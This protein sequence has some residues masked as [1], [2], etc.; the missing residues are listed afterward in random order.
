MS[1][2]QAL[3][4]QDSFMGK[5]LKLFNYEYPENPAAKGVAIVLN[6]EITNVEGV[7]VHYL[8][9]GK[10][11][12]AVIPWHGKRTITVLGIYAPTESDEEKI[13]FWNEMC[14]LWLTTDLPVP[15]AIGGDLNL[16]PDAID[17]LPHHTDSDAVIAA[18]LRFTRLMEVKD[19]YRQN[20]PDTKAYTHV[21]TRGT[22]S[23]IDRILVSPTLMKHCRHWEIEDVAGGLMDHRMVS[24]T[25]S[26]PGAPYIGKGRWVMPQFLL[27]DKEFISHAMEEAVKLEES[28]H[29]ARTDVSNAQTRFKSFKD[30]VLEFAQKKAKATVGASEK[31]RRALVGERETLLNNRA[32]D[33]PAVE[34]TLD[35]DTTDATGDQPT[36]E[37]SGH[38]ADGKSQEEIAELVAVIEKKIDDI[39]DRQR[40][41][42]RL[43]TRVRGYTELNHITKTDIMPEKGSKRSSEMAEIARDYH[44]D[45]QS[46][47]TDSRDRADI[48]PLSE[49]LTEGDVSTALAEA[50]F[51]KAAGINGIATEFW[52]RLESIN[53]ENKTREDGTPRKKTCDIIKV[54]TWVFNDIEEHGMVEGTDFSLGWMCPLFKKDKTDIANYRPITV[55]AAARAR[56][57]GST[58]PVARVPCPFR[59]R[60]FDTFH[61]T[62]TARLP[63]TTAR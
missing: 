3:E 23:R 13:N 21:S 63:T 27:H 39:V 34:V 33:P 54:L 1:A 8:I 35:P 20:N 22:L 17:R 51:G 44:N 59:R 7:K 9:P 43:E 47:G 15:D 38:P 5:R 52:R 32:P 45:L 41:R 25:I 2:A 53:K 30:S 24:V 50:A 49:K 55:R 37:E 16:V 28:I 11:I 58:A 18:Y 36:H 6:R 4:I 40:E 10:A 57:H 42:K 60:F 12:L 14:N 48:K 19:G 61:G 29:E 62:D 56:G 46:E 31:K 26:A